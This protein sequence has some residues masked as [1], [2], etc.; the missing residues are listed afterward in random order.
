MVDAIMTFWNT[1]PIGVLPSVII[2]VGVEWSS[3][4]L[5]MQVEYNSKTSLVRIAGISNMGPVNFTKPVKTTI[6]FVKQAN[7]V[8]KQ[9]CSASSSP[10]IPVLHLKSFKLWHD[11]APYDNV[12]TYKVQDLTR[13]YEFFVKTVVYRCALGDTS[14]GSDFPISCAVEGNDVHFFNI[15]ASTVPPIDGVDISHGDAAFRKSMIAY[16]FH[17]V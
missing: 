12:K 7:A 9:F 2:P 10:V 1:K 17:M 15:Y 16:G 3:G 4:S 6:S 11:Y 5:E 14:A 8:L 13:I